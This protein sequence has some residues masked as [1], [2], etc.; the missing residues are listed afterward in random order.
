[1]K[2][3]KHRKKAAIVGVIGVLLLLLATSCG[4]TDNEVDMEVKKSTWK[5]KTATYEDK[6]GWVYKCSYHYYFDGK[7]RENI[8]PVTFIIAN[9]RYRNGD[10]EFMMKN[11]E[12]PAAA[13]DMNK[14]ARFLGYNSDPKHKTVEEILASDWD[15]L[16]FEVLDKGIIYDLIH[17]VVNQEL[18]LKGKLEFEHTQGI[19]NEKIY[20]DGY[21]FQIG[22]QTGNGH[23]KVIVLDVL[24]QTG[25]L[26]SDYV[27]L[28]DL[29]AAGE[30]TADQMALYRRLKEIKEGIETEEDFCF[31]MT[32]FS[33]ETIAGVELSR[34][35]RMLSDVKKGDYLKYRHW[36]ELNETYEPESVEEVLPRNE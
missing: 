11:E 5:N 32:E 36:E 17:Q 9:L 8:T 4:K 33:S 14:L 2:V 15:G 24:Y 31:G 22:I 10:P 18:Q 25:V 35:Y 26:A 12:S 23:A 34:L 28:S 19:L 30:V 29:V 7:D 1:M 16:E 13:R 21:Q 6:D 27:Q 3:G 20:T